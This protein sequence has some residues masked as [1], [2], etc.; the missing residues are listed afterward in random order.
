MKRSPLAAFAAVSEVSRGACGREAACPRR[1]LRVV[2]RGVRTRVA[3]LP[4]VDLCGDD[5]GGDTFGVL[6]I[7]NLACRPLLTVVSR[8]SSLQ[9]K[10]SRATLSTIASELDA[11]WIVDG[12]VLQSGS[13]VQVLVQLLEASSARA[14]VTRTFTGQADTMRRIRPEIACAV[15]DEIADAVEAAGRR[16]RTA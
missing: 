1:R 8:N 11:D 16:I 5:R 2:R 14:L 6:L 15:A 4:F 10:Q 12:S 3:V 13:E 7:A 9:Y